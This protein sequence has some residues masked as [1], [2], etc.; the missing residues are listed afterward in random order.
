[1]AEHRGCRPL[2]VGAI[3]TMMRGHLQQAGLALLLNPETQSIRPISPHSLRHTVATLALNH[4][5]TIRQV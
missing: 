1:M 4:G 5:A 3:Q 2:G